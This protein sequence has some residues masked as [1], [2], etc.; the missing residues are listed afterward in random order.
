VNKVELFEVIR[1]EHFIQG[2]G[3]RRIAREQKV[4][5][6]LVRQALTNAIPPVRKAV[7]REALVLT[8]AL[9]GVIDGWLRGDR[10][11]PR[12]QQHTGRRIFQRLQGE[13]GYCGA[14]S[15]VRRYVGR[16]RRELSLGNSAFVLQVHCPGE[17]GEVDWYE[18]V[19][20]FPW[21]Q[22]TVQFFQMRACFSGREFH[23][24]FPRQTQQAFLEGHV[25]AFAY[26]GGVFKR[27]RYDNLGAAVKRVLRGRRREETDRFIALRSHYLFAAEFCQPG[28]A[29]AHE[30]GGVESGVGRFRRTHLVPV[31]QFDNYEALNRYIRA[32]CQADDRRRRAGR[33]QT[34]AEDW[35]VEGGQL[36]ALPGEPF[37]TA[38]ISTA[39]VS[40]KGLVS[41]Q[42][43]RYSVPIGLVG[44][45]VEVR[46]HARFI[47]VVQGGQIVALH[48]R[49]RGRHGI[50]VQLDHYLE[51]LREKPGA[52]KG[53]LAL[54]QARKAGGWPPDYD[55]LWVELV[56]RHGD[57]EGTRALVEVL[58]LHRQAPA[59]AV[60]QAVVQALAYG[61]CN[62]EAIG[63]LLRRIRDE[64]T[65]PVPLTELGTL[66]GY[67]RPAGDVRHYDVLLSGRVH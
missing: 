13:Y 65:S 9:Q 6:R 20:V 18:A 67:E 4:H 36:L 57:S 47:E 63:V 60:H 7:E 37:P 59:E 19:V 44:R 5:R 2:K 46:V 58:M 33:T 35:E 45:R 62:P 39:W 12:K 42:T 10:A 66:S 50:R 14:E 22:E 32:Q 16:R 8:K 26:F 21:G 24:A 53:S 31:P 25:A 30:K 64:A 28:A 52:L 49:L 61:C 17:E 43:N 54:H 15:T 3:I 55:R 38:E 1:R 11:A 34:V 29:G 23:L 41:S 56:T 48:E 40:A 27:V 51:L